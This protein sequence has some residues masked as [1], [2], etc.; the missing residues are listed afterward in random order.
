ML[1]IG[2]RG[3]CGYVAEN[4]IE[5]IDKAIELGVDGIE[6]DVFK[7]KS[8]ELVLFHDQTLSNLVGRPERIEKLTLEELSKCLINH[9]YSIPT[10]KKVLEKFTTPLFINIELKGVDTAV[11][12]SNMLN[13]FISKEKWQ[14]SSFIISSFQWKELEKLREVNKT[15]AIGV[16]IDRKKTINDAIEFANAINAQA[17][18][19]YFTLLNKKNVKK[20]K[21][22]NFKIF[23]WT[24]NNKKD[25]EYIRM[26]NIDGIISS[27]PDRI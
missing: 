13:E 21:N 9:K 19:P 17:I 1:K 18:H 4:T 22:N 7:C 5:S 2:H 24:V 15:I 14:E 27:Y 12:T 11:S 8:G 3:A 25:I 26:L 16:L 23:T 6:I 20:I 10:L